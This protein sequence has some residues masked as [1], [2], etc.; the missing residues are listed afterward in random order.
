MERVGDWYVSII[1]ESCLN[2]NNLLGATLYLFSGFY[3]GVTLIDLLLFA[4]LIS[5]VDPVAVLCVFEEIHVNQMLYICVFGE[6]LLNDA[7]TVVCVCVRFDCFTYF[8]FQVLYHTFG[9]MV[10][11]GGPNLEASDFAKAGSSFFLVALGGIGIGIVWAA[12]TGLVTKCQSHQVSIIVCLLFY[13]YSHHLNVVQ[14][15]ICLLFPY[16]AYLLAE[17]VHMSGILA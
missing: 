1:T 14:P 17:L 3:P 12:I 2:D 13:R 5:A 10:E 16:L 4:T 9:S 7:V 11:I 6:S 15:L 8:R